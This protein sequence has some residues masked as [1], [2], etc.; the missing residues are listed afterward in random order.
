MVYQ[1]PI[2][3]Q[4]FPSKLFRFRERIFQAFA[5]LALMGFLV[6][7]PALALVRMDTKTIDSALVYGMQSQRLGLADLLGP[8]WIEGENGTLLNV[9][10]PFMMLASKAS[11][12]GFSASP[13]KSDLQKARKRFGREVAFYSDTKNRV[14]VKFSVSFYGDNPDFARGYSATITGF[15]RGRDF[16]IKPAKQ[17]LDQKAD[18]VSGGQSG[19]AYEAINS[20]YFNFSDLENLQEFKLSLQSP[21]GAPVEFRMKNERLY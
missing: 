20:Y 17:I 5:L 9:Y 8:N 14:Q 19:A 12:A 21:V 16:E 2:F 13:T 4:Y 11:K 10:S 1:P 3:T 15:G 18:P 6:S 7:Q